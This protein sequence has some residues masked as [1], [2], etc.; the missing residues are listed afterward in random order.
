MGYNDKMNNN[1]HSVP[2]KKIDN[3]SKIIGIGPETI[4]VIPN[5][6]PK[7]DIEEFIK[8]GDSVVNTQPEKTHHW[9]VDS[10]YIERKPITSLLNKYTD[11]LR[12]KAEEVYGLKLNK[13][14]RVDFFIHPVGS[15]LEPHTDIIDYHQ[16]E[17]YGVGN[18][19]QEQEDVWPF[20]W[21]GHVSIIVYLNDGYEGG[22]LYFP[23]QDVEITPEPGMLVIFPGNLHFLHGVT[24]TKGTA[25]YTISLWTRFTDFKNELLD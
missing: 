14:R 22:V 7:K 10:Q 23:D 21:S 5:F 24:E 9:V 19:L 18:L 25:R 4:K 17:I 6:M 12:S 16:E 13:D 1:L 15:Y 11:L 8:F 3:I 20:L 2:S